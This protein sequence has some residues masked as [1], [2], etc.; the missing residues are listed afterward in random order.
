MSPVLADQSAPL[1]INFYSKSVPANQWSAS[2][3][4]K[5]AHIQWGR[6]VLHWAWEVYVNATENTKDTMKL[7]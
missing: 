7:V 3:C 5:Y 4:E 6:E 1:D 2:A